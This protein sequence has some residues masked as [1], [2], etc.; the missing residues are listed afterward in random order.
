MGGSTNAASTRAFTF[1]WGLASCVF[2]LPP[3]G[4]SRRQ[5]HNERERERR[6]NLAKL[7]EELAHA[8][9]LRFQPRQS[10]LLTEA[11]FALRRLRNFA[12]H[13]MLFANDCGDSTVYERLQKMRQ[14]YLSESDLSEHVRTSCSSNDAVTQQPELSQVQPVLQ[15]EQQRGEVD[16][17]RSRPPRLNTQQVAPIASSNTTTDANAAAIN[18][19][20]NNNN[21]NVNNS[22]SSSSSSSSNNNDGSAG[23]GV[24]AVPLL[25]QLR[26]TMPAECS[27]TPTTVFNAQLASPP[28]P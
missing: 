23:N 12:D 19:V 5:L 21:N 22:S 25:P 13:V 27:S 4:D 24:T 15:C 1:S 28:S 10:Q 9:N 2:C 18:T 14:Q 20:T 7:Q 11:S 3:T 8:L 17:K 6:R 26:A 16:E